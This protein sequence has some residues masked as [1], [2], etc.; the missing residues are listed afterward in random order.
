MTEK[1]CNRQKSVVSMETW[2]T[3]LV[4]EITTTTT[5]NRS[6]LSLVTFGPRRSNILFNQQPVARWHNVLRL[7][8]PLLPPLSS[9]S[10]SSF[11]RLPPAYIPPFATLPR[12]HVG[13]PPLSRP[14]LS[15]RR[16]C[17]LFRRLPF[18]WRQKH[19][20]SISVLRRLPRCSMGRWA[21]HKKY[22]ECIINLWCIIDSIMVRMMSKKSLCIAQCCCRK[23]TQN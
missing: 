10:S 7:T 9:S 19:L 21:R 4:I 17:L 14:A 5:K 12:Q 6:L 20:V 23:W 11:P 2:F 3:Q 15:S 16:G 22:C 13:L 1:N 8:S 18:V